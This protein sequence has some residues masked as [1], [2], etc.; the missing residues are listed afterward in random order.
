M[1]DLICEQVKWNAWNTFTHITACSIPLNF[2][3]LM[4]TGYFLFEKKAQEWNMHIK[5]RKGKEE[6]KKRNRK[7]GALSV[8]IIVLLLL[9]REYTLTD[10]LR[11]MNYT[12]T[13]EKHITIPLHKLYIFE[14]PLKFSS[15]LFFV[16]FISKENA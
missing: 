10:I 11:C 15:N 4:W 13:E 16:F 6:E 9:G 2:F 7:W 8:V 3:F 1:C 12:T 14:V 5:W